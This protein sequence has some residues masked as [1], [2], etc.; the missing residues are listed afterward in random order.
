M[1]KL[2]RF[3]NHLSIPF[4]KMDP[5]NDQPVHDVKS[6]PLDS[7]LER[8]D[9]YLKSVLRLDSETIQKLHR[10]CPSLRFK[11]LE[12]DLKPTVE[13]LTQHIGMPLSFVSKL[14]VKRPSLFEAS[15]VAFLKPIS[16]YFLKELKMEPER[17]F[18]ALLRRPSLIQKSVYRDIRPKVQLLRNITSM[19]ASSAGKIL[20]G[21]NDVFSKDLSELRVRVQQLGNLLD[22]RPIPL[23]QMLLRFP[24]V[25]SMRSETVSKKLNYLLKD[26]K[27]KPQ[28][29]IEFPFCLSYSL[30]NRMMRRFEVLEEKRIPHSTIRLTTI[31]RPKE[32][33]FFAMV[34]RQTASL[35][36]SQPTELHFP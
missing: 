14:F 16:E 17:F 20:L 3:F 22:L 26:A 33:Q 30:E 23:T 25:L 28:D 18:R 2:D 27:R 24:S 9:A 8:I 15:T 35:T 12:K 11:S 31:L 7:D 21:C 29:V 1:A 5:P 34:E 6:Y 10:R 32:S 4:T 19:D 36:P 13:F